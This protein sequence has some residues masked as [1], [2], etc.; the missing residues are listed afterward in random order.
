MEAWNINKVPSIFSFMG[1]QRQK[2]SDN[3]TYNKASYEIR[4]INTKNLV[5]YYNKLCIQKQAQLGQ[6]NVDEISNQELFE[7]KCLTK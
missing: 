7:E 4:D 5:N 3:I 2:D 6:Q 1:I